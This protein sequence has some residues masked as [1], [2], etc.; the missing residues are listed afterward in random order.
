MKNPQLLDIQVYRK[1][2]FLDL[3]KRMIENVNCKKTKR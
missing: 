2:T 1:D 3:I